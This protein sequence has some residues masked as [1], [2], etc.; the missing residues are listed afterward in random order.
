M[1]NY[2]VIGRKFDMFQKL[3]PVSSKFY[4]REEFEKYLCSITG[5]E[6]YAWL[7]SLGQMLCVKSDTYYEFVW[8]VAVHKMYPDG[9][10]YEN[11]SEI[12]PIPKETLNAILRRKY[13]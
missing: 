3:T 9:K 10:R 6:G 4:T 1:A 11:M 5:C 13:F 7:P 12:E 2:G 8:Q